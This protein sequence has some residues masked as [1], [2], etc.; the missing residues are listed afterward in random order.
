M[1]RSKK[2]IK[3]IY[4]F[5][6]QEGAVNLKAGFDDE[7]E[8]QQR[9]KLDYHV[10][11]DCKA[12]IAICRKIKNI[13][14]KIKVTLRRGVCC[15]RA[16]LPLRKTRRCEECIDNTHCGELKEHNFWK[17]LQTVKMV[18]ISDPELE[19]SLHP[20]VGELVFNVGGSPLGM[21]E[22]DFMHFFLRHDLCKPQ[23]I[24]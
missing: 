6:Q 10:I 18:D 13:R 23:Y 9:V 2:V 11:H 21:H 8:T 4:V 3:F 14:S 19:R 5:E 17:T 24:E 1:Y 12:A 7:L 16:N 20:D 15:D 22:D